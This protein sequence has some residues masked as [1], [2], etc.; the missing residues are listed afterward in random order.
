MKPGST[1][2]PSAR[3]VFLRPPSFSVIS[4]HSAAVEVSHQ[5]LA[6]RMTSP[7][8]VERHKAVLLAAHADGLDLGGDGFGLAQRAADGAGGGVA[9]GVRVLLLGAGRQIGNQI[10]FLRR[11][12]EDLAVAGVHDE[13]FGGLGAAVDAE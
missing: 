9:P 4:S 12:G 2:L 8:F 1:A 6:G 10:V 3:M 5:S 7:C 13:G 11:R